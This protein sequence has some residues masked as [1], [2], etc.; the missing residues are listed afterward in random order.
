MHVV[1]PD[2]ADVG[3]IAELKW[4]AEHADLHGIAIAP[5]G[6]ANGVLGLGTLVQVA[7]TLPDNLI[8]IEY[9]TADPAWWRDIVDGLAELTVVDGMI[10]VGDRPG[11]GVEIVPER[12]GP[13]LAEEDRDFSA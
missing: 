12:A 1:G 11:T 13:Y 3:A 10:A 4:I 5:H 2:P 9:T 7:A 6:T 8:A